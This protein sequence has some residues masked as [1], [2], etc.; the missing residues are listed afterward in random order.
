MITNPSYKI[1]HL[2]VLTSNFLPGPL[3][4]PALRTSCE[5]DVECLPNAVCKNNAT[6]TNQR[7]KICMCKDGFTE[8]KESCNCNYSYSSSS[9]HIYNLFLRHNKWPKRI[10]KNK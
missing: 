4:V 2:Y 7:L 6:Q 10:I 5:S 3:F 9:F 1:H 8:E